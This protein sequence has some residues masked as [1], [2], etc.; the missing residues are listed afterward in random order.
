M[1]PRRLLIAAAVASLV[2]ASLAAT[3]LRAPL[4]PVPPRVDPHAFVA[5][6]DQPWFPLVP[7]TVFAYVEREAGETRDDTVTVTRATRVVD[8]VTCVVVHDRLTRNG[9][10]LENTDD[11]YAQDRRGDL[12]YFGERTS[13]FHAGR[14]ST[15]GSW[16]SGVRGAR[17]GIAMPA[18]P[19]PGRA[20]RQEYR[21]GVAE[22]CARIEAVGDTV[23][24]PAGR[25]TGCVRTFEWSP[26]EHGHERKWY[27]RGVGL[28][29]AESSG[30]EVTELQSVIR[31]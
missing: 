23:V 10:V 25:F 18:R 11:W 9:R 7:G 17:A 16:A 8:G 28:V 4:P 2:A 26:L 14:T 29:R 31:P 19:T 15:A 5:R 1:A 27:A 21:R 13:E 6:V 3:P 24:V 30:G 22:D 12:W 20:Y